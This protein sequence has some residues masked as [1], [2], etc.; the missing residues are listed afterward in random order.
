MIQAMQLTGDQPQ[1]ST[2]WFCPLLLP[3]S[4]LTCNISYQAH[5]STSSAFQMCLN[6]LMNGII[7]CI[8]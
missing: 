6:V 7:Q 1:P 5:T 2:Q 8:D 4:P 3:S